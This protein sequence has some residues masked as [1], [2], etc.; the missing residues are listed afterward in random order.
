VFAS[1]YDQEKGEIKKNT[2][3]MDAAKE[4]MHQMISFINAKLK[5]PGEL[6]AL[7]PRFVRKKYHL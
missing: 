3:A 6:D 7:L 4:K 1:G 2:L 5:Y